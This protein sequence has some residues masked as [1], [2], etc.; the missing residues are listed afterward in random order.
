MKRVVLVSNRIVCRNVHGQTLT[1]V[2]IPSRFLMA[3]ITALYVCAFFPAAA[4]IKGVPCSLVK[5]KTK[6]KQ[7]NNQVQK[8]NVIKEGE[9]LE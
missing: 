8:T 6:D 1:K 5:N 7:I 4:C 3:S 2:S 9:G